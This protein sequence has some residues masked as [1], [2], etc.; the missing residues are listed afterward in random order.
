MKAKELRLEFGTLWRKTLDRTERALRI[1]GL[2]PI[3]TESTFMNDCGVDF[4]VRIVSNL[5]RRKK[6]KKVL[7]KNTVR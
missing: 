5:A 7:P 4:Q 2:L 6:K 3:S 1:G